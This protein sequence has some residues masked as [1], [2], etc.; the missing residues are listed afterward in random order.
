MPVLRINNNG[1]SKNT[2]NENISDENNEVNINDSNIDEDDKFIIYDQFATIIDL[3][4]S[5]FDKNSVFIGSDIFKYYVGDKS[6]TINIDVESNSDCDFYYR[7]LRVPE[8]TYIGQNIN[9][10]EKV[11]KT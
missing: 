7:L 3:S 5:D 9:S 6:V 8:K 2:N 11:Y 1:I 4:K 10:F